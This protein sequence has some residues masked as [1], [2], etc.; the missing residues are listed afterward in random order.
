MHV[1]PCINLCSRQ[2]VTEFTS[3]WY[4][5]ETFARLR[6]GKLAVHHLG[7]GIQTIFAR[8]L[9]TEELRC[10]DRGLLNGQHATTT[11]NVVI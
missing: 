4:I 5:A 9:V 10:I 2:S 7:A 1:H 6:L 3:S 8:F 11:M